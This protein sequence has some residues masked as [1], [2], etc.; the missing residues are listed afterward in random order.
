MKNA[1]SHELKAVFTCVFVCRQ[2]KRRRSPNPPC[3]SR[4]KSNPSRRCDQS[5][6]ES[7]FNLGIVFSDALDVSALIY[8]AGNDSRN[9]R[10]HPLGFCC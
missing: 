4:A 9:A 8:I 2:T 3:V 6:G 10:T 7:R 5:N 1:C